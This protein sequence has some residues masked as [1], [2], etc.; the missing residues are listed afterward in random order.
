MSSLASH[1]SNRTEQFAG[2]LTLHAEVPLLSVGPH[3]LCG[4]SRNADRKGIAP[5]ELRQTTLS[6]VANAGPCGD[7]VLSHADDPAGIGVPR[8]AL[9]GTGIGLIPG[10][11]FE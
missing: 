2:K 4:D 6:N 3:R 5:G 11:V 8:A 7:T 9:E 1:I 10:A